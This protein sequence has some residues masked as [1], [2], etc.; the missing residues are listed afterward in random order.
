VRG[1]RPL[2][3]RAVELDELRQAFASGIGKSR[4]SE[5]LAH[6][7]TGEGA[8]VHFGRC[9]E[10]G[11]APPFWPWIEIV[12][13]LIDGV[14]RDEL[15][16]LLGQTAPDIVQ[17]VP[18]VADRAGVTSVSTL[19]P[20][21]ERFRLFDAVNTVI[22]RCAAAGS[23]LLIFEDLHAADPPTLELLA[24]VSQRLARAR[25]LIVGAYRDVEARLAPGVAEILTK[26]G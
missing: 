3:G 5:E 1:G 14:S 26:I 18:E 25:V 24:F 13:G 15:P 19:A 9:W 16:A 4:L 20:I 10:V 6:H 11:G 12:R 7:A 2:V 8:A 17:L 22:Q 21:G 23:L